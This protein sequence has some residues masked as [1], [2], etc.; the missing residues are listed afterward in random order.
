MA[1][2]ENY[3]SPTGLPPETKDLGEKLKGLQSFLQHQ[4][5]I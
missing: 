4:T 3:E 1:R 2:D 5:I